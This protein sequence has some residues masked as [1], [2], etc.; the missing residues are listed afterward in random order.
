MS[1]VRETHNR[2]KIWQKKSKPRQNFMSS[3]RKRSGSKAK[4]NNKD[5]MGFETPGRLSESKKPKS[6]SELEEFSDEL[7]CGFQ[8][9]EEV[10]DFTLRYGTL[11]R[12]LH[13]LYHPNV[14]GKQIFSPSRLHSSP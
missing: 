5:A 4:A 13:A 3:A 2:P 7:E 10:Q 12:V 11:E 9:D 8:W 6:P 14:S 1:K